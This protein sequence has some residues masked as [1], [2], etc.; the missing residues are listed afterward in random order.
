M[1]ANEQNA[2]VLRGNLVLSSGGAHVLV[3]GNDGVLRC[4][5]SSTGAMVWTFET[6][7]PIRLGPIAF[8]SAGREQLLC[9]SDSNT[10]WILDGVSGRPRGTVT[11]SGIPVG[12]SLVGSTL[13][14]VSRD[15]WLERFAL[16]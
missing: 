14:T 5:D 12:I 11:T 4:L 8:Q 7:A 13:E 10:I 6:G 3:G 9:A 16:G 2:V 15:G 1:P